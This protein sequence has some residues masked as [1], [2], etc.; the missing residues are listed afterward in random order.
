MISVLVLI[1]FRHSLLPVFGLWHLG[2][3][4]SYV[5]DEKK[6]TFFKKNVKNE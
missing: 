2:I 1:Q 5:Q 6:E 3:S 4:L